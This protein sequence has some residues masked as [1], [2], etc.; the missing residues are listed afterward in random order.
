M[1]IKV[2]RGEGV[3]QQQLNNIIAVTR[4]YCSSQRE[5]IA[6]VKGGVVLNR[7]IYTKL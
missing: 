4:E 2:V 6:I 1:L 3:L 5:Y 7:P